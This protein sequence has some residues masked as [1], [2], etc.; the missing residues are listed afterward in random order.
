MILHHKHK[1]SQNYAL[2]KNITEIILYNLYNV[3]NIYYIYLSLI[4][5]L[6]YNFQY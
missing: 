2:Y 5:F 4:I 1:T 6:R 3:I